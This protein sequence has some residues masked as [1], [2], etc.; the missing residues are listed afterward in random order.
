MMHHAR[1]VCFG[2]VLIGMPAWSACDGGA[3]ASDSG[4]GGTDDAADSDV[5]D[6]FE[7]DDGVF[8]E[9]IVM[10]P[11][12][13]DRVVDPGEGCDDGNRLNGDECDWLCRPGPGSF[14]YPGLDPDVPAI[15]DTGPHVVVVGLAERPVRERLAWG[16][17][18]YGL[19]YVIRTPYLAVRFRVLD[20]EGRTV[21]G[22]WT[23]P[24]AFGE[25]AVGLAWNGADFAVF[26]QELRISILKLARL[27]PA[28]VLV[29]ERNVR[30]LP[31]GIEWF[32]LEEMIWN[33]GRYFLTSLA[34][35][36]APAG[37]DAL[38]E[39]VGPDGDLLPLSAW[40]GSPYGLGT[41]LAVDDGVAAVRGR[42][43]FIFDRNLELLRWSG[44]IADSSV[45]PVPCASDVVATEEG[46]LVFSAM[47][48]AYDQPMDLWVSG[49]DLAGTMVMPPR[50]IL[51]D[52]ISE[53]SE[54]WLRGAYGPAGAAVAYGVPDHDTGE[55]EIRIV[56]TDRWGNIR[57]GPA[58]VLDVDVGVATG[59]AP[60]QLVADDSGYAV[61]AA[62]SFRG[63]NGGGRNL[64]FRRYV[65]AR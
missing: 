54:S 51:P 34:S 50:M 44:F 29:A 59:T 24:V 27:D 14:E 43:A 1:F 7:T 40:L 18:V 12:C 62:I 30:R 19:A 33:A 63:G 58:A 36:S 42:Y 31:A 9:T 45:P 5:R 6:A 55:Y 41:L 37:P 28:A 2:V 61:L 8:R 57:S 56:N 46:F 22:P 15:T 53:T 49:F 17:G 38:L 11:V 25:P 52:F 3:P 39:A 20:I 10:P 4:D 60:F 13:G 32:F 65:P 48:M 47:F 26:W 23:R 35:P 21:A 64:I 16:P